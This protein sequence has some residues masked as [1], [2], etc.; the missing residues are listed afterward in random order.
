MVD[1]DFLRRAVERGIVTEVQA[2]A[3]AGLGREMTSASPDFTD[4][5]EHVRFLTGFA[6]IFVTIGVLLVL[7]TVCSL[8]A[9]TA[10]QTVGWISVAAIAWGL[11]ELF[12]RRRRMALPSIVL[13]VAFV[14]GVF[15][16]SATLLGDRSF[17]P[18][19]GADVLPS[20]AAA[21]AALA[22]A[23]LHYRRFHVPITVAA[24]AAAAVAMVVLLG[25]AALP[26]LASRYL[27]VFLAVLGVAVFALA[28]RYDL[29]DPARV[30][31]RSDVA[32]WLHML[33][34]PLIVHPV[35][36]FL[37]PSM[38]QMSS[39]TA[40]A[41]LGLVLLLA[42]VALVTDRRAILVSGLVYAS[43]A[44]G[45]LIREVGFER[46]ALPFSL[47]A[48]GLFVLGLSVAWTPL[49]GAIL[50][51]LPA[52]LAARLPRPIGDR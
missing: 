24:G 50:R 4:D 43:V 12:S 34:A 14:A 35:L 44:L 3:L 25:S 15:L 29:S 11:A 21:T 19:R 6:D 39:G 7:T 20:L 37:R 17:L 2:V 22:G 10:G 28:M 8:A 49:R 51:A 48:L 18:A 36:G 38:A 1:A 16:A 33:A 52:P 30:T 31:R 32:F 47:L 26:I 42:F 23:I 40:F 13:L 9:E 41:G 45:T 46:K 27:D 5:D